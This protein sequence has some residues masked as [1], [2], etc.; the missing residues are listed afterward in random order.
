MDE[1]RAISR[2]LEHAGISNFIEE[3]KKVYL[4]D[5]ADSYESSFDL[6]IKQEDFSKADQVM[7]ERAYQMAEVSDDHFLNSL[8]NDELMDVI[9]KTDEWGEENYAVARRLLEGRG[10]RLS[11]EYVDSLR[12]KRS[13]DIHKVIKAEPMLI[14]VGYISVILAGVFAIGIGLYLYYAVRIDEDGKQFRLY[15]SA[16]RGTGIFMT[17]LGVLSL[18]IYILAYFLK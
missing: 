3:N 16:S 13:K 9:Y 10:K 8:S 5:T 1:A 4:D 14:V 18:L 6:Q 17:F 2:L 11:D 7:E 12:K 15:D